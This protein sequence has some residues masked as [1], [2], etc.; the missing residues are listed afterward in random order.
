MDS[1]CRNEEVVGNVVDGHV[2]AYFSNRYQH[3]YK[4]ISSIFKEKPSNSF[5]I[6]LNVRNKCGF[7]WYLSKNGDFAQ[8]LCWKLISKGVSYIINRSAR[9]QTI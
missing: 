6:S 3:E 7:I 4:G 8:M 1:P 2:N 9:Q 5:R